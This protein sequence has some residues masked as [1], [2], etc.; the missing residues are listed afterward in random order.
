VLLEGPLGAGK[1]TFAR[2]LLKALGVTQPPEGSPTF[3]IAHEYQGAQGEVVHLDL[4][5]VETEEELDLAGIPGYFWERE[6]I[7]L[8]EWTSRFPKFEEALARE[9]NAWRVTL[10]FA[11]SPERRSVRIER[12][13]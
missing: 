11:E 10:V 2:F 9:G 7:A 6:L 3:A 8:S 1:T 4:Y 5:R 13:V 12:Y